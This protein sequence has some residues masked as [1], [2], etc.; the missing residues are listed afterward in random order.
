MATRKLLATTTVTHQNAGPPVKPLHDAAAF[1]ADFH[2]E[3]SGLPKYTPDLVHT[4]IRGKEVLPQGDNVPGTVRWQIDAGVMQDVSDGIITYGFATQNH[5]TGIINS[6]SFGDGTGYSPFT[7]AQQAAARIAVQNWDDLIA[8]KFVEV[9][10]G[11]GASDYGRQTMDITLAN[12][13]TGPAQAAA[14]YPGYD[15]QYS[16]LAGDVWVADPRVNGSNAQLQPGQYGLQTLNHELGHSLGLSHPGN[17]NFGDDSDGDGVPDPINYTGDAEYFQDSNQYS[18]M[19]YFDSYETGAQNI[20]WNLMRFVYPSTPMV[21]DVAVIQ[22]K[23]GADMTTRTGDTTYGFNSTADVTNAALKFLPGEMATVFT[24]WDAGGKDT[25]NLSGFYTNSVIDL[26]EGAYS[27]AGGW[28]AYNPALLGIDPGAIGSTAALA[29]INANNTA[30]GFGSRMSPPALGADFLYRVYFEGDVVH[31]T[32]GLI[33]EGLSWKTITGTDQHYLME[34]NIGI[35]YGAVIENGVG[36]HGDDRING[37]QADNGLWGN[38]GNDLLLGLG[39]N[40]MLNGG[41]GNDLLNGGA[42]QDTLTGGGGN[43]TF[44]FTDLGL[45]DLIT[46]F[47]AGDQIDLTALYPGAI[48]FVGGAALSAIGDVNYINGVISGNFAGDNNAD[49]SVV[50]AGMPAI[51]PDAVGF[52]G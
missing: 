39:G 9:K 19:S 34:Q 29:L 30:A 26:R 18:I 17:Y 13:Y 31:P 5:A 14:F 51:Q 40:D 7:A 3:T 27:S 22:A 46:D 1:N 4:F 47:N 2:W 35:A 43:D 48:N 21:D 37:N 32:A 6:P 50:L 42:G 25:L 24:I 44:V 16:R 49:F 10:S 23:Y 15:H 41:V 33:N 45:G 8:A 52:H 20:D 12:T 36:G 11:P 38:D 28:G